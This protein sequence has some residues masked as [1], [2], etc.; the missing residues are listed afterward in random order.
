MVDPKMV[1]LSVYNTL[2]HLRH[3]V[4]T[5]NR[6]A[7][8]V[9][10]WA[11]MEMQERYELLAANGC[12]NV[13]EFNQRVREAAPLLRPKDAN[14]AF[15]ERRY[16]GKV[17]PY[18]VV[19]IEELADLMMTVQNEVETP[20][21]LLAQKARAIGIH[22][23][24]ATQRPS[25]NVITGLIKANFPSRIA[26]RVASQVDSR[27]II[28]GVG[29]EALLGN[30]DMLFIPPGRSEPARLQ[31]AYITGEESERLMRWYDGRREA[32]R[33]ARVGVAE[34][35]AAAAEED[36]ILE[37]VRRREAEQSAADDGEESAPGERDKLFR[38]AA[39]VVIQ[40]QHGSTLLLQRRLKV[41]YGRAARIID[42]LHAAGVLGPPDGPKPRDVLVGLDDLDRICR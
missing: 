5:D 30:G 42:Q 36:D 7:A 18:L 40:N 32:R 31:G 39:E 19:V 16:V 28:D 22:L 2:P 15:E 14:V 6:D 20:L 4:I 38:E 8:A 33:V 29:A 25:V 1:E 35:E 23:L 10:K 3:K 13:Q 34:P 11:V 17:L 27:T 9:F 12:R 24:L 37:A 41:G 26:F 21:A